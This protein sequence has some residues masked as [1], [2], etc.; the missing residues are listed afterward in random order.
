MANPGLAVFDKT[1]A[2]DTS[3]SAISGLIIINALMKA[4]QQCLTAPASVLMPPPWL[5]MAVAQP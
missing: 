1:F 3:L 2:A 4:F 5:G